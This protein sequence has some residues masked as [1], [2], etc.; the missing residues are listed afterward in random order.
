MKAKFEAY[1]KLVGGLGHPGV[2]RWV[3]VEFSSWSIPLLTGFKLIFPGLITCYWFWA[4]WVKHI[5][6]VY[7]WENNRGVCCGLLG[8]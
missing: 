6:L 7:A 4:W 5:D 1:T 3:C 8:L 2:E